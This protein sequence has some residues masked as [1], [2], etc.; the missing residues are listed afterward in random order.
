MNNIAAGESASFDLTG[1]WID[2]EL[3]ELLFTENNDQ[4]G[5]TQIRYQFDRN[6]LVFLRAILTEF[7]DSQPAG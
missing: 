7:L 1:R 2:E 4:L 3:C 6:E 5:I